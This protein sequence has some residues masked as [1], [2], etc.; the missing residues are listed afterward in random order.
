MKNTRTPLM[1]RIWDTC[2]LYIPFA[3]MAM[4]ALGTY[5]MVRATPDTVTPVETPLQSK[6]PDYFMEDFSVKSFDAKGQLR[7]DIRG[8]KSRHAPDTKLLEIDAFTLRSYD[9]NRRLTTATAQRGITNADASEVQLLG[10]AV[11]VREADKRD[12]NK[13]SPQM[14][15]RSE[16]LHAFMH[17]EQ[18][19]SH[20]P[21]ELTHGNDR[22]TADSLHFDNV[23]QVLLLQG[24]V[25]S[26]LVPNN[27]D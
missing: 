21:V 20:K 27:R 26:L 11:I 15:Y 10:N 17:T 14:E 1:W 2:V 24:R 12:A 22:F 16:F 6:Q 5:W 13:P 8:D 7:S 18:I 23:E 3:C 9:E 25:H 4:L 19:K